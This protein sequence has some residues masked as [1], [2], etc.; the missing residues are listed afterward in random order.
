MPKSKKHNISKKQAQQFRGQMLDWYDRHQR[1]LPW[2]ATKGQM[3]DPYHV[4]LSEI[5]LQ[6]TTVAA[7]APYFIKFLGL[8][9]TVHDLANAAQEEVM[10]AWA[11]LGY[12]ARARNLHKCAQIVSTEYKGTFP[13]T[14][15]ELKTLP[16]IGDYTSAAITAI[17]F[18]KPATVVDGNI[19]RIMARY[20]AIE[21]A[22]PK[23]KPTL[24]ALA[25]DIFENFEE[26]PGDLAQ[27][28]MDL[29]ATI[30]IPKAPRCILCPISENCRGRAQGIA[31]TL[32]KK[33]KKKAQPQKIG[34]VYWIE[35]DAGEVLLH[36]R[37]PK[38]LLGGMIALPTSSWVK[39]KPSAPKFLQKRT[40]D[41]SVSIHHTF[42]HFH[43]ELKLRTARYHD[44]APDEH[45]WLAANEIDPQSFP[46]VFKKALNIFLKQA[47]K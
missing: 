45:F 24:K 26:R 31:E 1:Q 27:A 44:N 30:C 21:D 14:Q 19:E 5:M 13:Q 15:G 36:R 3:P 39:A 28:L 41:L 22:L 40:Q 42:T 9:P 7:V 4:W 17:A 11:G 25:G 29:G 37:P 20:F 38:G 34:H 33:E 18:N 12:Y 35:N 23:S 47:G 43:L 32:P 6:Q 16:G 10:S 46:T 8:W 2:R